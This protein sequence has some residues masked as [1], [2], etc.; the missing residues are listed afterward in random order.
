[1]N[2][3]QKNTGREQKIKANLV[4]S[5]N[6]SE[7]DIRG[8]CSQEVLS[9]LEAEFKRYRYKRY[10]YNYNNIITVYNV[11]IVD[12]D[13]KNYHKVGEM[14]GLSYNDII[15]NEYVVSAFRYSDERQRSWL[16]R[17]GYSSLTEAREDGY[18][19]AD[20]IVSAF[21]ED[22]SNDEAINLIEQIIK[23]K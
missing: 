15:K 14:D 19:S 11:T 6:G 12:D 9:I 18:R 4:I 21:W 23:I 2:N 8:L 5:A 16:N 13:N 17:H 1:M 10:R 3:E 7:Y 20:D 22:G